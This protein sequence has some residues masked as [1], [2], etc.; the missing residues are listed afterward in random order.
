MDDH[1]HGSRF[2][3]VIAGIGI[4]ALAGVLLAPLS[5][6]EKARCDQMPST[7]HNFSLVILI[8]AIS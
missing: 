7:R 8:L 2:I 5:G 6:S 4:G 1:N 3:Y